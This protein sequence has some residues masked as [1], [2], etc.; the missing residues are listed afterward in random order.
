MFIDK[1][2]KKEEDKYPDLSHRENKSPNYFLYS[3]VIVLGL[4]ALVAVFLLFS[5]KNKGPV[6]H[7]D[8]ENENKDATTTI[9]AR[10]PSDFGKNDNNQTK[11]GSSTDELKAENLSFGNFYEKR[12]DDFISE[13]KSYDLPLNSK[14]DVS[15]YYDMSRKINLEDLLNDINKYGFA[16]SDGKFKS[17]NFFDMYRE[18][19]QND[20]PVV[21]TTDFMFYLHQNI[22]KRAYRDIEENIFYE[23]MW[24]INKNLFDVAL[25][26]Y[27]KRMLEVGV[28]ND[29]ILEA[30]RLETAFFAVALKL[31]EPMD[32]QINNQANFVDGKKFT[33]QEADLFNTE[34]PDFLKNME[35]EK[36]VELIRAANSESKSPVMLYKKN[37][38]DFAVPASYSDNAKLNNFFLAMKW[39]NSPFPIYNISQECEDC[40]LDEND[41]LINMAA[42]SYISNDL[43]SDQN[44]KNK[45]A[46]IYKFIAYFSGLRQDLTYL[47]YNE[48]MTDLFGPGYD[49]ESVFTTESKRRNSDIK[50]LRDKIIENKFSALGGTIDRQTGRKYIGMR[51]LQENYWPNEYIFNNFVGKDMVYQGSEKDLAI[52]AC[53]LDSSRFYRCISLGADLLEITGMPVSGGDYFIQNSAYVNYEN[54]AND[55][56]KEIAKFDIYTWNNNIFWSTLDT[57]KK[58]FEYPSDKKPVFMKSNKWEK[59]KDINT[60]L[61][62]W[63]NLHLDKDE[64]ANYNET[65]GSNFGAGFSCSMYNYVEPNINFYNELISKNNVLLSMLAALQVTQKT[66]SI[67]NELKDFNIDLEKM[68]AISKKEL[69]NTAIDNDDCVFIKNFTINYVIDT[70]AKKSI[71]LEYGNFRLNESIEGLS[72]LILVYNHPA[73]DKKI[74]AV[75]PIFK[76]S[77]SR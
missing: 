5:S 36:E 27:K 20:V 7:V 35:V 2:W 29:P 11:F 31:L 42:A 68:I 72:E 65:R 59:E 50:A 70:K 75:G 69:S 17:D 24:E 28:A 57:S 18:L 43:Y 23:N 61:G 47:H 41:W 14:T 45:W 64:F 19:I 62:A 54:K 32:K 6:V 4:I 26:R 76:Y 10:L 12:K 66:N 37:Y 3:M 38:K 33:Q 22:F 25:T 60:A 1:E 9:P 44:M 74:M 56:K 40:L 30:Q 67:S 53:P 34:L 63:V 58:L 49:V 13:L 71:N 16:I 51:L 52:S 73:E 46:M 55:L 39:Y 15:N 8:V 21:V 48:A 77:E